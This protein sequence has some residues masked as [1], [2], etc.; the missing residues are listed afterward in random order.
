[1]SSL[2]RKI[3]GLL[4]SY[5]KC[6]EHRIE[7]GDS[8]LVCGDPELIV[9]V[10]SFLRDRDAKSIHSL[11]GLNPLKVMEES[12]MS[13]QSALP[14]TH[15]PHCVAKGGL[16]GLAKAFVVLELAA[17][18]LY[19]GPW[20]KEYKLVKMYSGM[21]THCVKPVLST[22]QILELFGLLGYKAGPTRS[23]EL[24]LSSAVST[25]DFRGLSFVFFAARCECRLLL[26]GLGKH[27]GVVEWELGLVQERMKGHTL[28]VALDNTKRRLEAAGP[29]EDDPLE[30]SDID[31]YTDDGLEEEGQ[32][33]KVTHDVGDTPRS[34]SWLEHSSITTTFSAPAA[35]TYS[36]GVSSPSSTSTS[37]REPVCVSTLNCQ[38]TKTS[39]TGAASSSAKS[40]SAAA[41][42]TQQSESTYVDSTR[43]G[44]E[45]VDLYSRVSGVQSSLKMPEISPE[46][47][48]I[49]KC[50]SHYG[51]CIQNCID[52]N[53]SHNV[54]CDILK[55]CVKNMHQVQF[56]DKE[57]TV[58]K[59][60]NNMGA[61]PRSSQRGSLKEKGVRSPL[62]NNIAASF[63]SLM[64]SASEASVSQLSSS[65]I[66]FHDCCNPAKPDPQ[67]TCISCWVFHSG[68]C[69]GV[70]ICQAEHE[71]HP[72]GVCS[73]GTVCTREPLILCRYCGTEY[74]QDC[75][76]RRP[77]ACACGQTFDQSSSV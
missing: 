52:C 3:G 34:P 11:L 31:L 1:M 77:V 64:L 66:P 12:L 32:Q 46:G 76:Y 51:Q 63:P 67:F 56:P 44:Y 20:R 38:L 6:L 68:S 2:E 15:G 41:P 8:T 28:Q 10:V 74:C 45:R 49:C 42:F 50:I 33:R 17:L 5:R 7:H 54:T 9:E 21:F 26:T 55:A 16:A 23:D 27:A 73:C 61:R 70:D 62:P 47:L 40:N 30:L 35:V 36:N 65:P 58:E 60:D 48:Y 19:L 53:T 18:N 59:R 22:P 24:R 37:P 13:M 4:E 29:A 14:S 69:T 57:T 43:S 72:L 71:V 25:D 75:W 39:P